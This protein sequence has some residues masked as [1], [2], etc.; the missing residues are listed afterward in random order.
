LPKKGLLDLVLIKKFFLSI[1]SF[2][3]ERRT[4]AK[5]LK[6]ERKREK[7]K[8]IKKSKSKKKFFTFLLKGR[9]SRMKQQGAVP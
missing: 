1:S 5:F 4:S 2:G 7:E 6:K 3:H 9:N 8:K